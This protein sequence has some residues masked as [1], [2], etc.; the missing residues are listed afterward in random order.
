[1]HSMKLLTAILV[2]A[3]VQDA[4]ARDIKVTFGQSIQ[5]AVDEASPGDRVL[6]QPGIYRGPGRYCPTDSTKL[7]AVVVSKNG[8]SLVAEPRPE[9]P[10][11]LENSGNQTQ[12]IAFA[13]PGVSPAQCL[14]DARNRIK[15]A[16]V[17]GFVVR[18]F[19]D[20]GIFLFCVEGFRVSSNSTLD[21]KIYGIFPVLSSDGLIN[22]NVAAGAHDTGIYIG[23][24]LNVHVTEN[25]AH[26]NVSGF[27]VE[28]SIDIEVDH[29]ESFDNT[30]GIL[31]FIE[32]G[33]V[34]MV[35]RNNQIHD[36]FVHDNNSPNS[37]AVPGDDVCLVP[38]GIGISG[39][40]GDHNVIAHNRVTGNK[41]IG[42]L[43]TDMCTALQIPLIPPSSCNL[44]FDPLPRTTRIEFNTAQG[45][46]SNPTPSLPGADLLWTASGTGNCWFRNVATVVVPPN[47]PVCPQPSATKE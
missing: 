13:K 33:N 37:C 31:M 15:E 17:S 1:M 6:V 22:S 3:W 41:T 44:G 38:P 46:G 11:I 47:L 23:Q 14:S 16:Q 2:G 30:A 34:I 43:L 5:A 39:A 21:N 7:C 4:T 28:N 12:G 25:I 10:V 32:P 18:N 42:I 36:N 9:Q 45:N 29:N 20:S 27:E 19:N 24:S 8:I 26:D 35:S 40:A